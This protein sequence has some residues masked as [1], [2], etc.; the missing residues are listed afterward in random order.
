M[1]PAGMISGTFPGG[2]LPAATAAL[3]TSATDKSV[4]TSSISS[5]R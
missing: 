5:G 3:T 1:Q 4:W 2:Q